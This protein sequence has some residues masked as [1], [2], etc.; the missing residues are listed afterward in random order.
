[1]NNLITNVG[2]ALTRTGSRMLFKAQKFAPELLIGTGAIAIIAGTVMA[3]KATKKAENAISE[4][5][6]DLK[7]IEDQHESGIMSDNQ[8]RHDTRMIKAQMMGKLMGVYAIPAAVITTGFVLIFT[9][10]GI[11]KKRNGAMLAA[12]NALE[13][14]FQKYRERVKADE[15]GLERDHR[16]MFGD[17]EFPRE[18]DEVSVD[19]I[20]DINKK[21][22]TLANATGYG[23]YTFEFSKFSSTHWSPHEMSNLNTIRSAED[24][25][26]R[27]LRLYGHLFLNEILKYMGMEEV[28]WGQL[29]GWIRGDK[30]SD[31]EVQIL[32]TD[33]RR[34]LE[35][36]YD[37][38]KKPIWL[39]F[40]CDGAIWDRI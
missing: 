25:A 8:A 34:D 31:N 30:N 38:W 2:T 9:S 17:D 21:G 20:H 11:M 14:A 22:I 32:A 16:Y 4:C 7:R 40:N 29:V 27:Q 23:P 19:D 35:L 15:D 33:S 6:D 36:D 13:A 5:Q 39:E 37:G 18:N 24:W 12:Y 10:H 3:C 1:M 28:S 26:N